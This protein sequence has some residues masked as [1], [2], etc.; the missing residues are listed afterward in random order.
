MNGAVSASQQLHMANVYATLFGR[1]GAGA[2]SSP[3]PLLQLQAAVAQDGQGQGQGQGTLLLQ[4]GRQCFMFDWLVPWRF[5]RS[6]KSLFERTIDGLSELKKKK[7]GKT[8]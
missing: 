3:P 7:L 6:R 4:I 8:R 2:G 5:E 1:L